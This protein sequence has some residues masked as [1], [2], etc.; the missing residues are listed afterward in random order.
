MLQPFPCSLSVPFLSCIR[1]QGNTRGFIIGHC[2]IRLLQIS[3]PDW[4]MRCQFSA[5]HD[6]FPVVGCRQQ[7]AA[8]GRSNS[9]CISGNGAIAQLGLARYATANCW[10][11]LCPSTQNNSHWCFSTCTNWHQQPRIASDQAAMKRRITDD[12]SR[13]M[14]STLHTL[15]LCVRLQN[16]FVCACKVWFFLK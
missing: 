13:V 8:V 1:V 2:I 14:F 16:K 15:T 6:G 7:H 9:S 3:N 10:L 4:L 5:H 12:T 11:L